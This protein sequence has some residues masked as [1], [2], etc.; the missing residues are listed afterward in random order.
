MHER[1]VHRHIAVGHLKGVGAFVDFGNGNLP[2]G[3][4]HGR[5]TLGGAAALRKR[6]TY[7]FEFIILKRRHGEGHLPVA[8]IEVA[9][10]LVG[11]DG[12]VLDI[13]ADGNDACRPNHRAGDVVDRGESRGA[14]NRK[15]LAKVDGTAFVFA[16]HVDI[17]VGGVGPAQA[18]I[19]VLGRATGI[20]R[21]ADGVKASVAGLGGYLSA[22]DGDGTACATAAVRTPT[23]STANA[24]AV[25]AA[26]SVDDTTADGDFERAIAVATANAGTAAV[27][28][29]MRR[30]FTAGDDD[31]AAAAVVAAA[32]AGRPIAAGSVNLAAMDID[33]TVL[34]HALGLLSRADAGTFGALNGEVAAVDG[35]GAMRLRLFAADAGTSTHRVI[36]NKA[37]HVL[38]IALGVDGER[39]RFIPV[40]VHPYTL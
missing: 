22:G 40:I 37:A 14:F 38:A 36:N 31:V 3:A 15:R 25:A 26:C 34:R 2:I 29:A 28:T 21:V 33:I 17:V 7:L 8:G 23:S 4:P 1:G 5:H 32:H 16:R 10:I 12:A 19:I 13:S 9:H 18:D 20:V 11:N 39:V 35:D 27:V 6:D 24:G 30:E